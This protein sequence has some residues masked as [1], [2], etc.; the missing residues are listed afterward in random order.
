MEQEIHGQDKDYEAQR[1]NLLNSML[2]NENKDLIIKFDTLCYIQEKIGKPR[3]T[4]LIGNIR[5]VAE[6]LGKDFEKVS[7]DDLKICLIQI[8]EKENLSIWTKQGYRVVMKKF[9]S[10]V[11]YGNDYKEKIRLE[12]YPHLVRWI[13]TGIKSKDVPKVKASDI[14]T[15]EE[16]QLLI[17]SAQS[18]RDKAF[19]SL[20][21]ELGARI[22]EVGNLNVKDVTRT[23]Y[24][25]LIDLKGKTGTR[26]PLVVFSASALSAWLNT[27]PLKNT[28]EAPLWVMK[29]SGEY[30]RM[31]YDSFRA[32]FTR[33]TERAKIAKR[34][35]PHLFRHTRV[36]HILLDKSMNESQVKV[37]FG[38]TPGSNMLAQYSHITSSDVNDAI[39]S[40]HGIKKL[41]DKEDKLKIKKCVFCSEINPNEAKF[42]YKCSNPVDE[43]EA[44]QLFEKRREVEGEIKRFIELVKESLSEEKLR[45]LIHKISP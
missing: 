9:F 26:T 30:K 32:M 17:S 19:I 29:F 3:R 44:I 36:S 42:C 16:V 8:E 7:I 14:L 2:S 15:K 31:M 20:L 4:K 23:E 33:I 21:Y 18:I 27:H 34:V 40:M 39:L 37:Y 41:D 38:W 10:W 25:Y 13:N 5:R 12:G 1:R 28:P 11:V 6:L 35:H 43:K 45:E 24:G 22:G